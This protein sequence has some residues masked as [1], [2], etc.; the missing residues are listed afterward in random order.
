[1]SQGVKFNRTEAIIKG[2]TE[3]NLNFPPFQSF[4]TPIRPSPFPSGSEPGE[5]YAAR[6]SPAKGESD[7]DCQTFALSVIRSMM[8]NNS[9]SSDWEIVNPHEEDHLLPGPDH[10]NKYSG[11]LKLDLGG[12]TLHP[13]QK[14]SS[15]WNICAILASLSLRHC[16]L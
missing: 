3:Q 4:P 5:I 15:A 13:R 16:N 7:C 14:I 10:A 6:A 1:M 11:F 2:N 9:D 12:V 8:D